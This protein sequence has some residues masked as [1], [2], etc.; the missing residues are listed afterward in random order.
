VL[1][2]PTIHPIPSPTHLLT[3]ISPS[4]PPS[5]VHQ[6]ST[7][8]GTSFPT[9]ARKGS[10]YVLGQWPS[11]CILFGSWLSVWELWVSLWCWPSCGVAISFMF[12]SPSSNSPIECPTSV[13]WLAVS[14]FI[15]FSQ[16][17]AEPLRG[18]AG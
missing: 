3:P 12:F 7:G 14:M 10:L 11:P 2:C 16:L 5:L 17:L 15:C 18:Q 13:Q 8:L 4:Q 9:E 1:P 6:V